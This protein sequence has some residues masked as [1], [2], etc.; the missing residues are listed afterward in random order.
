MKL[1]LAIIATLVGL[2]VALPEPVSTLSI[3]AERDLGEE[4]ILTFYD[5]DGSDIETRD[6]FNL[7]K[8]CGSNSVK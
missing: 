6:V 3:L 8:R 5:Q 7:E 2:A 1:S 4:G